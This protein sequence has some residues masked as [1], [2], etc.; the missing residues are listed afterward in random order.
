MPRR[1]GVVPWV[2]LFFGKNAGLSFV[3]EKFFLSKKDTSKYKMG[4]SSMKISIYVNHPPTKKKR[5]KKVRI[6]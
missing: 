6:I 2:F 3:D 4:T 1:R 5:K